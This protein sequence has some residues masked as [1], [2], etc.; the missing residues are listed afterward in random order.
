[1]SNYDS[2]PAPEQALD[3]LIQLSR[4]SIKRSKS[5][6]SVKNGVLNALQ[7]FA[8]DFLSD[9]AFAP[10]RMQ[11]YGQGE[12]VSRY[13][14][15]YHLVTC[16][17]NVQ[18]KALWY[19]FYPYVVISSPHIDS[20]LYSL[21]FDTLTTPQVLQAALDSRYCEL[22]YDCADDMQA[23][24]LASVFSEWY[25]P[26]TDY[27]SGEGESGCTREIERYQHSLAA[28]DFAAVKAGTERI[29][30]H[31]P[32]D[33]AAILLNVS[34]R[35]ADV[36]NADE[37]SREASL[38]SIYDYICEVIPDCPDDKNLTY[39][40]YYRGLCNLGLTSFVPSRLENAKEDLN[41]CLSITPGFQLAQFMLNA[42]DAKMG[43]D[44]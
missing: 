5:D 25:A 42:I 11:V 14:M 15:V 18:L 12:S 6:E 41:T 21:T 38:T 9:T 26:Y 31:N 33:Y 24:G 10:K 44:A 23:A 29:L 36:G 34:A 3:Y 8:T 35:I 17:E 19:I 7:Q 43:G 32:Y 30:D 13:E 39:L 28:G 22:I 40:Y 20:E 4:A 27:K 37:N 16:C 2:T 1:M